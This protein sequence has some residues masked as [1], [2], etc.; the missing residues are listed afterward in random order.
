[1]PLGR[2]WDGAPFTDQKPENSAMRESFL[3]PC[4]GWKSPLRSKGRT[5]PV[6]F[7]RACMPF[8]VPVFRE[9]LLCS[10]CCAWRLLWESRIPKLWISSGPMAGERE[11]SPAVHCRGKTQRM[12]L[13]ERYCRWG[14]LRGLQSRGG[15]CIS[16]EQ[17]SRRRPAGGCPRCRM[18]PAYR[19]K[20]C[21]GN[22]FAAKLV[23]GVVFPAGGSYGGSFPTGPR[24]VLLDTER[25]DF[26]GKLCGGLA[27]MPGLPQ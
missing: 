3:K 24:S 14:F 12:L 21:G 20:L 23:H 27:G 19:R 16:P 11:F 26:A 8:A 17:N 18:G 1:M 25:L 4:R 2:H 22:S 5:G 15:C 10:A 9:F 7:Q 6:R 13:L